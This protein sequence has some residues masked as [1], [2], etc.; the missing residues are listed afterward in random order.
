[1]KNT[2]MSLDDLKRYID[3]GD[4]GQE[5]LEGILE[6]LYRHQEDV[7]EKVRMYQENL[8]LLEKKIQFYEER[9]KVGNNEELFDRFVKESK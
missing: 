9:R 1:M 3:Y 8:R 7:K 6:I 4:K 2:E 5:G